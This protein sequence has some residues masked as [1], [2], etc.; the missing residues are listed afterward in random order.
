MNGRSQLDRLREVLVRVIGAA[1]VPDDIGVDVPLAEDGLGLDSVE[2]LQVVLGCEA[3]FGITFE[4]AQDLIGD[5]L[6]T[7]GTLAELIRRRTAA[8]SRATP[9][10]AISR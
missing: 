2:L 5:G 8:P 1:R 3:E 6:K 10:R 9:A 4:P 7:V